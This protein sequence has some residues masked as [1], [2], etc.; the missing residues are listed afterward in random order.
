MRANLKARF[1][2]L[3]PS[4]VRAIED[5][6]SGVKEL[7]CPS[8]KAR[9]EYAVPTSIS[10]RAALG[11]LDRIG[12]GPTSTSII[13]P[14]APEGGDL[15]ILMDTLVGLPYSE[16]CQIAKAILPEHLELLADIGLRS[17]LGDGVVQVDA[18]N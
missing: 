18:S 4:F 14:G 2:A 8:C 3:G 1:E 13:R 16:R 15:Q 17:L 9:H 10:V 6:V 5:A 12:M 7:V 11:G